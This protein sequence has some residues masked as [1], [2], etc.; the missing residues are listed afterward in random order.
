MEESKKDGIN[1][2][3]VF[4]LVLAMI[5]TGVGVFTNS[6]NLSTGQVTYVNGELSVIPYES[7]YIAIG[8]INILCA[9][10]LI[11]SMFMVLLEKKTG[12]CIFFTA[13]FIN[14]A[15]ITYMKGEWGLHFGIAAISCVLLPLL[16]QLKKNGVSAWKTIMGK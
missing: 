13:Q 1:R 10:A 14:A 4:V 3:I 5:R 16:L 9:I 12:V 11:A 8:V 7:M 2:L 6:Q 15:C